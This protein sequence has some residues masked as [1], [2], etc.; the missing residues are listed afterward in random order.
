MGGVD[1]LRCVRYE[2]G[3]KTIDHVMRNIIN[4]TVGSV[5]YVESGTYNYTFTSSNDGNGGYADRTFS[6]VGYIL[7]SSVKADDVD[8]YP[9]ILVDSN[10]GNPSILFYKNVSCSFQY[11]KFYTGNNCN[12]GKRVIKSLFINFSIYLFI[13]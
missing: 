10:D 6:V 7:G 8:T 9:I 2:F 4:A 13:Y 1:T 3:C 11:V 5:V 12:E